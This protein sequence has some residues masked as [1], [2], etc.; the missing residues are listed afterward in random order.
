MRCN[1]KPHP[2]TPGRP[3]CPLVGGTR[4]HGRVATDSNPPTHTAI[5]NP[6]STIPPTSPPCGISI[7]PRFPASCQPCQWT[8]HPCWRQGLPA[9]RH[10]DARL[11]QQRPQQAGDDAG[12]GARRHHA[13]RP[14][15]AHLGES[16]REGR[17]QVDGGV[18]AGGSGV[19]SARAGGGRPAAGC[20]A[21]GRGH[22]SPLGRQRRYLPL[23]PGGG[24]FP[25]GRIRTAVHAR[26]AP[27]RIPSKG[28]ESRVAKKC[29][30][31]AGWLDLCP[32]LGQEAA[33]LPHF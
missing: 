4:G 32:R 6:C 30:W 23:L 31:M 8:Y 27:I 13:L 28:A 17:V 33:F 29:A 26:G 1:H 20:S 14:A 11:A 12:E 21:R 7:P 9:Q 2:A 24:R 5:S 19:G 16:D 10:V 25:G 15:H 22:V 3:A 18:A